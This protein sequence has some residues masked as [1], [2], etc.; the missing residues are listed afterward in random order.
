VDSSG[1]VWTCF[2]SATD[3]FSRFDYFFVSEGL[4]PEVIREQTRVVH[5]PL[6]YEASDHRPVVAVF[7]AV[8]Q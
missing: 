4:L 5:D 7:Q 2:Q 8:D 1:D 6:T 3:S